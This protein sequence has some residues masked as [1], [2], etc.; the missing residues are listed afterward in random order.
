MLYIQEGGP[1]GGYALER[2]GMFDV[3]TL[4]AEL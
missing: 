3:G 4:K 1:K 2:P